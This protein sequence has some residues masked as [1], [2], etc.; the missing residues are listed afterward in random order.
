MNFDGWILVMNGGQMLVGKRVVGVL[1][2]EASP[3]LTFAEGGP[4]I[5]S[6]RVDGKEID[7]EQISRLSPVYDLMTSV[8][9]SPAGI[10]I[11]RQLAPVL[12]ADVPYVNLPA[13]Y[14]WLPITA[15]SAT[16]QREIAKGVEQAEELRSKIKLGDLGL[17]SAK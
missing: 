3:S 15:L 11:R 6:V 14:A 13:S 12:F 17:A 8:Q 2:G 9:P 16:M 1:L 4:L 7:G 10:G 5:D